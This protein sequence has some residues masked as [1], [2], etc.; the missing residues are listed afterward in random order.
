LGNCTQA[1]LG[2]NGRDAI[3]SSDPRLLI[4]GSLRVLYLG[5]ITNK[6]EPEKNEILEGPGMDHLKK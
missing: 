1:I 6:N 2:F 5:T 3:Y 4:L